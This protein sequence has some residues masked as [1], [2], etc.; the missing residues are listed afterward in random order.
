MDKTE[1]NTNQVETNKP[2]KTF[3]YNGQLPKVP[4][5]ALSETSQ[6]FIEWCA[7]LLTDEELAR[8][9]SAL[10][11]FT[12]PGG[13]G[14][15]THS[16]LS[17]FDKQP[18]THSWLDI[19][20]PSRYLGRRDPIALNANFFFLFE[21][22]HRALAGAA[23]ET[24]QARRAAEI[25][26]AGLT[27]KLNLDKEQIPVAMNKDTPLSMDQMKYLFSATRIPGDPQD[28]LRSFYSDA[29]P[30]PSTARHIILFH[31]GE[32][33]KLD[34]VAD[35]AKAHN[36]ATIEQAITTLLANAATEPEAAH[37]IGHLTTM[38]RAEWATTRAELLR[39]SQQNQTSLDLIETALFAIN[40][41]DTSP[42]S[43]LEACDQLLHESSGNRW[44]DKALELVIF[45]NGMAG[46][47]I[48]HCGLDGTTI[49]NFVDYILTIKEDAL[50][51]NAATEGTPPP[52]P[53]K[54]RF[55]LDES[56]QAKIN[57][58]A[59]AF[60]QLT[61]TTATRTFDFTEFGADHIKTL[62]MSPDAFVQCAM[63]LAHKRT[64]TFIGATYE[65]IA[66]R[67]FERGRTEA[68]RTVTPEVITFVKTMED[69]AQSPAEKAASFREAAE[70]HSARARECQQGNAPE[71]HLWELQNIYNRNPENF[72]SGFLARLFSK[73][74]SR[75][76]IDEALALFDSPGWVKM[77]ADSLS[78]SSAPSPTIKYFGFG[79]TG[80]GCIGV[81]YLV[82]K[83]EMN[84]YLSTASGE[85]DAV[86]GFISNWQAAMLELSA[87]LQE[88]AE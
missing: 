10:A 53:E 34:V 14:E 30:G 1:A 9:K 67:Q 52:T 45:E 64:K 39:K 55:D 16:A 47:N 51:Q 48:E 25:I 11:A 46:I 70:K 50:L 60:H 27:Y 69:T 71:Q 37:P 68:M 26:V 35:N 6:R 58:A 80:P 42:A 24:T 61:T 74:L 75:Q 41:D 63:Q 78:T 56:L 87:L 49:L 5:P 44:Y 8:T 85:E 86:A 66:T 15:Q 73:G 23:T 79:S 22:D 17:D 88:T 20:W 31:K 19:F 4:L 82:R 59:A 29:Q 57:A 76:Q 54:L 36:L 62:K 77:R 21:P 38:R 2:P 12:S 28:T 65:S 7:P 83:E 32:I 40:L 72:Q 13:L 43:D 84:C 18:E 81:G 3:A 33:Y